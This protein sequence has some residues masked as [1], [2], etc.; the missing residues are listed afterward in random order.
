MESIITAAIIGGTFGLATALVNKGIFTPKRVEYDKDGILD[1]HIDNIGHKY[2][3]ERV[4]IIGYHNGGYWADGTSIKKFTIRNEYY[5]AKYTTT[6]MPSLQSVSTG[7]LKEM[8]SLLMNENIVFE[9]D[10]NKS[11]VNLLVK[12]SYYKIMQEYGT[13]ATIAVAIKKK[14]F[15]WRKFKYETVMIA[16]LHFNWGL[17]TKA[18]SDKFLETDKDCLPICNDINII[19][20]MFEPKRIMFDILET[21]L[22]KVQ[23][24]KQTL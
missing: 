10:I 17:A 1:S 23:K 6:V 15:N 3:C 24:V 19:L 21:L 11:S 7:M 16:S 2:G 14:I 9:A 5:N 20:N 18:W 12:P 8:P 4:T 22:L 13:C